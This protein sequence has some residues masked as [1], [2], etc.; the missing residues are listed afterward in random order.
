M[1]LFVQKIVG[2]KIESQDLNS[3]D[4]ILL[5]SDH[6]SDILDSVEK[7]NIVEFL[8][9]DSSTMAG[10]EKELLKYTGNLHIAPEVN[11]RR[12]SAERNFGFLTKRVGLVKSTIFSIVSKPMFISALSRKILYPDDI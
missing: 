4:D 7:A 9:D 12:E 2:R 10:F 11:F 6:D 1:E 5:I 8:G 3:D